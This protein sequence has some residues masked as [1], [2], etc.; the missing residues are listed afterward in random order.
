MTTTVES[1]QPRGAE[2]WPLSVKG[3][4]ALADLGLIPKNTELLYFHFQ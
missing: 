1:M 4:R 2:L 3:Y